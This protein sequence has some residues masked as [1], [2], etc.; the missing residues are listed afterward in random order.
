MSVVL[1][2]RGNDL[3]I[4]KA[5]LWSRIRMHLMACRW[6]RDLAAGVS[7][8]A[9]IEHSMRARHLAAQEQRMITA[10]ALSRELDEA[11]RVTHRPLTRFTPHTVVMSPARRAAI[12]ASERELRQL[13]AKLDSPEPVAAPGL[14]C[15][16]ILVTDG[17][18]PLLDAGRCHELHAACREALRLLELSDLV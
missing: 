1:L 5:G 18:G 6:D 11:S 17:A 13:S 12:L 16:W 7:P 4:R 10:R 14:A 2:E 8:D 3:F 9:T 15:S